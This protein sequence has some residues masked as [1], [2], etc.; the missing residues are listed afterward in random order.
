MK[1]LFSNFL[2]TMDLISCRLGKSLVTVLLL[3]LGFLLS[4]M[5]LLSVNI[6]D[7]DHIQY[8]KNVTLPELA[9]WQTRMGIASKKQTLP[10]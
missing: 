2:I 7:Y 8:Q 6:A 1:S 3:T 9:V 10:K 4:G 5:T